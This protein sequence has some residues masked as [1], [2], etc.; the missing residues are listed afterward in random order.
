M[1]EPFLELRERLLHAG[2]APRHVRRYVKELR[3]HLADLT[4]EEAHAGSARAEAEM[5]AMA[6]LGSVDDLAQAMIDQ[7]QFRSWCTRAPWAVFSVA[8]VLWL[9]GAFDVACLLWWSGW[10]LFL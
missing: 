2:V 1:Q 4:A 7:R 9:A 3:E 5:R 10:K 6:R 8:P